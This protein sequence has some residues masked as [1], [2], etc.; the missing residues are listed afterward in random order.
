MATKQEIRDRE[1]YIKGIKS[2]ID[3][4]IEDNYDKLVETDKDQDMIEVARKFYNEIEDMVEELEM[5]KDNINE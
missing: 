5:L 2:N 1:K 3:K 4:L